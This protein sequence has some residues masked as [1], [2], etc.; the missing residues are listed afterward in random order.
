M[1]DS[2]GIIGG[3]LPHGVRGPPPPLR[4]SGQERLPNVHIVIKGVS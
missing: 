4:R 3:G 2:F 1:K